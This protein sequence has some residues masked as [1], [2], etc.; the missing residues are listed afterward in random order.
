[1]HLNR[2]C[3]WRCVGVEG[4][5]HWMIVWE[6]QTWQWRCVGAVGAK[7]E[8]MAVEQ[9]VTGGVSGLYGKVQWIIH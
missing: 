4:K 6:R 3:H 1:M 5:V 7:V 8:M 9:A 2:L